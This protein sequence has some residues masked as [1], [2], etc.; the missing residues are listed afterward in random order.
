[1]DTTA[2]IYTPQNLEELEAH[3]NSKIEELQASIDHL[4]NSRASLVD[5]KIFLERQIDSF[6]ETLMQ[7]VVEGEI[8]ESVG[9]VLAGCF[10]RDLNRKVNV[11]VRAEGNL[12]LI[13]PLD[14][15]IDD[16]ESE[17]SVSIDTF[18]L[19]SVS[20]EYEEMSITSVE[21]E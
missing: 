13:L 16:L 12:E 6:M 20:V 9:D 8:E 11:Y 18:G 1:M 14:L 7:Y 21:V 2:R 15:D 17:L 19:S 4:A 10:N 3:K 5:T